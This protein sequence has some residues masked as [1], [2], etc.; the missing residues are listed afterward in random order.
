MT[1]R[2]FTN[3]L[4]Y[5]LGVSIVFNDESTSHHSGVLLIPEY[6]NIRFFPED[7]QKL[8]NLSQSVK[9]LDTLELILNSMGIDYDNFMYKANRV[10]PCEE[11]MDLSVLAELRLEFGAG[12]VGFDENGDQID[13]Q[14]QDLGIADEF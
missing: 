7:G 5:L 2:K 6:S 8:Q 13:P 9:S 10:V 1:L 11:L 12:Q 14:H 4:G 3:S